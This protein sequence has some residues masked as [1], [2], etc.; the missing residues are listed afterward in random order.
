MP[1]R[2]A[3]NKLLICGGILLCSA[4]PA[5]WARADQQVPAQPNAVRRQL[6]QPPP[7][8]SPAKVPVKPAQP[9]AVQNQAAPAPKPP[10]KP[11]DAAAKKPV[12]PPKLAKTT[13]PTPA[14]V[15][16]AKPA[17]EEAAKPEEKKKDVKGVEVAGS[18]AT[19][20]PEGPPAVKRDPFSPLISANA[21]KPGNA[22]PE[23]L[24]PG[25]AGLVIGTLRVDGIVSGPNGMIAIVSNA[26]DRV[27]FLREGD[28]L[29]D[30]SVEH[31][32]LDTVSFHETGKDPFGKPVEREVSKA[33]INPSLGE[34]P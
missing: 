12:A 20:V 11:A 8:A 18:A 4:L 30:G 7:A 19:T 32:A 9:S 13:P 27:Y 10:V 16:P 14:S 3:M 29:Y 17:K 33:L 31:I 23:H 2:T 24:P 5:T 1:N 15:A 34:A 6:N 26:Q 28:R 25:K 22:L 21:V